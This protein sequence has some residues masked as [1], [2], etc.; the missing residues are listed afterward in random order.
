MQFLKRDGGMARPTS[1]PHLRQVGTGS[2]VGGM[3]HQK[4]C[5][6]ELHR[7]ENPQRNTCRKPHRCI[8]IFEPHRR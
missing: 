3:Y 8:P 1:M 2:K 4:S 7:M 5:H 6:G